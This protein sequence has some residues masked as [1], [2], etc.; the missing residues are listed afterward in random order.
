MDVLEV[1]EEEGPFAALDAFA[2][3]AWKLGDELDAWLKENRSS[4]SALDADRIVSSIA[5]LRG[6]AVAMG[7]E[8]P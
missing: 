3:V 6:T 1:M 7:R 4:L 2:D 5:S 8:E